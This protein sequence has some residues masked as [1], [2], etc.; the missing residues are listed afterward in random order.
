[1]NGSASPKLEERRRAPVVSLS[2]LDHLWF[3]VTGTLCNLTC[4]HCFISSS[5]TNHNFELLS[6]DAVRRTLDASLALGV[7][8][9]YF[10]GGEPFLHPD[11]TEI[12]EATLAVGPATVLTNG[13][14]FKE[15]DLDRL[16]AAEA[17]SPYSLEIR[18]S[19]DGYSADMN[20]ALRGAGSFQKAVGGMATLLAHG[21]LPIL[22]VA[23]TWEDGRN[24]EMFH[25]F[26]SL[27]KSLGCARP[28]VKILPTLRLGAEAKRTRGYEPGEHVTEEMMEG[29][30]ASQLVCT[31]SRTVTEKGVFVCPILLDSKEARLGGTLEESLGPYALQH[32]ACYTCYVGGAIC[33]NFSSEASGGV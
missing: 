12:L 17:R 4:T 3:Q 21:F 1:M 2:H 6:L 11:M 25:R 10:T 32:A 26:V 8:E 23:Q 29:Y 27:L 30:D 24:D 7:K 33:S 19:I 9:Y 13:T 20:D 15:H 14:L 28:R 16:A 22:T 5:P 31:H 18:V